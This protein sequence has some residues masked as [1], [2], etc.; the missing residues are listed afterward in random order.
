MK[1]AF[2]GSSASFA[3]LENQWASRWANRNSLNW[4]SKGQKNIEIKKERE[5]EREKKETGKKEGRK[6]KKKK[7]IKGKTR[8]EKNMWSN[9]D[10]ELTKITDRYTKPQVQELQRMSNRI[11]NKQI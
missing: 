2:N 8:K 7:M 4:N 1:N 5:R 6:R 3:L 11:N 9:N 10:W